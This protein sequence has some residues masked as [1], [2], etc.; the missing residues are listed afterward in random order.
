MFKYL[1]MRL[2]GHMV[3]VFLTL[4]D[5]AKFCFPIKTIFVLIMHSSD[6]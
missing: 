2:L 4:L 5:N 1:G 6:I 3:D